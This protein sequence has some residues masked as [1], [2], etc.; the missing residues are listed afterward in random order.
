[1]RLV[2]EFEVIEAV[3]RSR[4]E[5]CGHVGSSECAR[6]DLADRQIDPPDFAAFR[7]EVNHARRSPNG[8]PYS[9]GGIDD[10]A[11]GETGTLDL[12][13]SAAI[14]Q[15]ACR[16]VVVEHVRKAQPRPIVPRLRLGTVSF[17]PVLTPYLAVSW[18]SGRQIDE[19]AG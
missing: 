3:T 13:E 18:L 8:D 15:G 16:G 2:S 11:I 5:G 10:E 14:A 19:A 1:M 17:I 12:R 9:S 4:D 6:G 7:I